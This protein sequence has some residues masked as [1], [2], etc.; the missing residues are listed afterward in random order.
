[1]RI[2]KTGDTS[3]TWQGIWSCGHCKCKWEMTTE[4]KAPRRQSDQ[5]DGDAWVMNCPC[6]HKEIWRDVKVV[7]R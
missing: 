1:M 2:I 6:C 3:E 5:R 4:D 7:I